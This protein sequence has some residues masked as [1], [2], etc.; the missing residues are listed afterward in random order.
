MGGWDELNFF[1]R[2]SSF[3]EVRGETRFKGPLF[4][5][6]SRSTSS[7]WGF[8]FQPVFP[9]VGTI[10]LGV[11]ITACCLCV[12]APLPLML[13]LLVSCRGMCN[14]PQNEQPPAIKSGP[15]TRGGGVGGEAGGARTPS[16]GLGLGLS[17]ESAANPPAG[18]A[19]AATAMAAGGDGNMHG[20]A[21]EAKTNTNTDNDN[22][23]NA[24]TSHPLLVPPPLPRA[25]PGGM[26]LDAPGVVSGVREREVK[27]PAPMKIAVGGG[28][29]GG[30]REGGKRGGR[31]L[32][33]PLPGESRG[34]MAGG[35][36]KGAPGGFPGVRHRSEMGA[37]KLGGRAA[38]ASK[39]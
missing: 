4:V 15:S 33:L 9:H 26:V 2:S 17:S 6:F 10:F 24:D 32:G 27:P 31:G 11:D 35:G 14:D 23:T 8:N 37:V 12:Q 16:P 3:I 13:L 39:R 34:V 22:D 28:S 30:D 20:R 21:R 5:R 18:A 25:P 38:A 1:T 19:G 7:K 29:G 36:G